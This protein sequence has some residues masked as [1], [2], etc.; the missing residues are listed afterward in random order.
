M[1]K[2]KYKYFVVIEHIDEKMHIVQ[3]KTYNGV[4]VVV[5]VLINSKSSSSSRAVAG[6]DVRFY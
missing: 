5:V 6:A 1:Y 4:C 3:E 2:Y